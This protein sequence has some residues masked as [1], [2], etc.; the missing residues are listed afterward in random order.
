V[1]KLV[2]E[3]RLRRVDLRQANHEYVGAFDKALLFH[4]V[5]MDL[6]HSPQLS[7]AA[8]YGENGTSHKNPETGLKFAR[9]RPITITTADAKLAVTGKPK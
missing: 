8:G 5:R 3:G 2:R 1:E 7:E 9:S 4:V 6:C